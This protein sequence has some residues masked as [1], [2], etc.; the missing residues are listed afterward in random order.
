MHAFVTGATGFI[1]RRLV[2]R[3]LGNGGDVTALVRDH[4]Q[5]LAGPAAIAHGALEDPVDALASAMRGHTVLFHLAGRVSFDPS[6]RADLTR[7]NSEG[8][9]KVLSAASVA[10]VARTVIVS[11][12]CT[13]GLSKRPDRILDEDAPFEP[14]L[15][16]R[17][18]YLHSKKLAEQHAMA[19]AEA[20]QWVTVVNPT[21][22][23]GPG[24]RTLN[25]GTLVRQVA[26]A[27]LLPV[28]AGGTNVIDLDDVV[29]G[30]LAAAS[31][32]RSGRR[33]IL[34]GANLRF[35]AIIDRIGEIIDR[36]P[37]RVPMPS[38]ARTPLVAAVWA[39]NQL[40]RNR[41]LTPQIIGDTFAFKY[42]SSH[43]AAAELGWRA[44]RDFG[45]TL[46]RA[47]DYYRREGLIASPAG[48]AI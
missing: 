44:R 39:M 46:A 37:I 8:T 14:E 7:V 1:G 9:R 38:A 48:A 17:N 32:G 30:I 45:E 43:R 28:P 31:R 47:W 40:T 3:V 12:A 24:D 26:R 6:Q 11:S 22:V 19:A 41:L 5:E 18:P 10:G 20:G 21:T 2:Q 4:G 36:R 27:V 25:S 29:E 15:A 13:I 16:K 34:G 35:S 33:Y 23:F 42:Y